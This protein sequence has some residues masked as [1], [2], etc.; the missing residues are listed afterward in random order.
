MLPKASVAGVVPSWPTGCA[1]PVPVTLTV[2]GEFGAL[3]AIEM[4]PDI[5]PD[6]VGV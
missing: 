1:V 5:A 6:V 3:L 4:C 2:K